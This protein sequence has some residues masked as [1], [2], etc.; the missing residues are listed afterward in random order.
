MFDSLLKSFDAFDHAVDKKWESLRGNKVADRVAYTA[1]E[2]GDFGVVWML[3]AGLHALIGQPRPGRALVRLGV[4]LAFESIVVNQG[5]KRVFNRKRPAVNADAVH[6]LR[7]PSTSSFPSGHST[8]AIT[9][10]VL[11]TETLPLPAPLVWTAA[12]VVAASRAH[13]KMHH[14]SDVVGGVVVGYI[15]GRLIKR[16]VQI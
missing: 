16:Y 7:K 10:A 15:V 12:G 3:V 8:S 1:S 6:A 2:V 13:V 9:A 4:A 14:P 5:L 11:L